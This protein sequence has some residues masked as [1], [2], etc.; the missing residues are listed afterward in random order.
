VVSHHCVESVDRPVAEQA[1]QARRSPPEQR[2]DDR[3]AGVLGN[4]LDHGTGDFRFVEFVGTTTNEVR[5]LPASRRK[6][7]PAQVRIHG[8]GLVE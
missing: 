6:V 2:S 8:S 7:S 4:R 5:E 3:V 1:R